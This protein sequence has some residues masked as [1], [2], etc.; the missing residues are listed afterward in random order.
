M[1]H[2]PIF[3]LKIN[4]WWNLHKYT[5]ICGS[6]IPIKPTAIQLMITK[7]MNFKAIVEFQRSLLVFNLD[8][9]S[10][11]TNEKKS[12]EFVCRGRDFFGVFK[13][14]KYI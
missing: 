10:K 4:R 14:F 12:E 7:P 3:N 8:L 11:L 5:P 9:K 1:N 2:S 13:C 6:R